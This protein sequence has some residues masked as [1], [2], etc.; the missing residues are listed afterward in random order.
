MKKK[1]GHDPGLALC[2]AQTS[3]RFL[4]LQETVALQ[5]RREI[6]PL[7]KL[8]ETVPAGE[9]FEF[10][11]IWGGGF[12]PSLDADFPGVMLFVLHVIFAFGKLPFGAACCSR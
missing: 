8:K 9:G 12:Q 2:C 11:Q 1:K 7:K 6:H 10:C 5:V 3:P 4:L